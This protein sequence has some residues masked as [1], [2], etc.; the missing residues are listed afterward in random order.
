MEVLW[1]RIDRRALVVTALCIV[2]WRLLDQIPVIDIQRQF[3]ERRLELYSQPGFFAA[4]GPNSIV[5]NAYSVGVQ[6]IGPYVNALI[7]VNLLAL[8]SARVRN[9]TD[10]RRWTV[11]LALLLALGQA[12][13]WTVLGQNVGALPGTMDWSSRLFV[14]IQLTGGTAVMIMVAGTLDEFGLGFGYGPWLL[15]VLGYV[16]SGVHRLA[17]SLATTPSVEALYRPLAVWA[18][19]TVGLTAIVVAALLAV[20]RLSVEGKTVE[21]RLLTSGVYRPPQFAISVMFV[22][23]I[24]ANYNI[25]QSW[26]QWFVANWHPYGAI[27]WLDAAY[28]A[29]EASLVVLFALFITAVDFRI[30]PAPQ[31]TF[32]H[33]ERLAVISGLFLALVAIASPVAAHFATI[34]AG[35]FISFSGFALVLVVT[36]VLTVV[37]AIEGYST[38]VPLTAAPLGIP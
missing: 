23:T 5:F 22:P 24:L 1:A 15:Y 13:G 28:L 12:Y 4:I 30:V 31:G 25:Q 33:V 20:R 10:L 17:D 14:C 2:L 8:I 16:A 6:G 11:A 29:I 34:D 38:V 37:R 27:P 35:A 3:V 36:I 18:I 19:F 26:A 32:R 21:L 9:T 7:I